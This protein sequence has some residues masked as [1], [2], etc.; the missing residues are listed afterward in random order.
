MH[1][2]DRQ[3]LELEASSGPHEITEAEIHDLGIQLLEL[4]SEVELEQFID[5]I[6]RLRVEHPLGPPTADLI[7]GALVGLAGLKGRALAGDLGTVGATALGTS[8]VSAIDRRLEDYGKRVIANRSLSAATAPPELSAP[9]SAAALPA[10][11]PKAPVGQRRKR[12]GRQKE[13]EIAQ[14]ELEFGETEL[15][16]S[17]D[18]VRLILR[19]LDTA[20]TLP[21]TVPPASAARVAIADATRATIPQLVPVVRSLVDVPRAALPAQAITPRPAAPT[22]RT[23]TFTAVASPNGLGGE[24]RPLRDGDTV[25]LRLI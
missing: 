15:E 5:D 1:D 23:A 18:V 22:A 3:Q 24:G 9:T 2:Y 19:A 8:I 4:E 11:Q 16:I 7:K 25:V 21:S 20:A 12:K 17:A 10:A 13:F 6:A 14:G